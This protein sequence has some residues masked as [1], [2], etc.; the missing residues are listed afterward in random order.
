MSPTRIVVGALG[1]IYIVIGILGFLGEPIVASA[2]HADMPSASGD[3]MGIFP[4]NVLH[5]VVHLAIGAILLFG[6]TEVGRAIMV[7]R[8][9][10]ATYALVGVLGIIAPDTFGIMPIGGADVWLH[11][12]T[13]AVLFGV[14]LLE[15]RDEDLRTA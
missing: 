1:A 5:N 6:A 12:G 8:G 13:A 15:D 14:T 9:V 11:F 7:A 4:I 10:A 3:L 2:S